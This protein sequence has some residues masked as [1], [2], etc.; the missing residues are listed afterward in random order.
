MLEAAQE[1]MTV[2]AGKKKK[3]KIEDFCVERPKILHFSYFC[4]DFGKSKVAEV[5]RQV[6]EMGGVGPNP[7]ELGGFR[8]K[9]SELG[10]QP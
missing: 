6:D 8:P 1:L 7:S 3:A 4:G 2:N 9:L 5:T 10:A